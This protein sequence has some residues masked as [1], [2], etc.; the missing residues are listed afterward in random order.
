MWLQYLGEEMDEF[1]GRTYYEPG[2]NIVLP[3][4]MLPGLVLVPGQT[5]PLHLFQPQ[6]TEIDVIYTSFLKHFTSNSVLGL[7]TVN[8][9]KQS[10]DIYLS[11]CIYAAVAFGTN[12]DNNP[13]SFVSLPV[14]CSITTCFIETDNQIYC[15]KPGCLLHDLVF[16]FQSV[17]MMKN[18]VEKDRTFGLVNAR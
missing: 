9:N 6:V 5:L 7:Q 16:F 18:I 1:S 15:L 3:L 8:Y 13:K 17:A 10:T 11:T 4:L 2:S 12:S 14:C